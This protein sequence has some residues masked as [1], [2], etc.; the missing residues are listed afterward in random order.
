MVKALYEQ[1]RK[2]AQRLRSLLPDGRTDL[3]DETDAAFG[4]LVKMIHR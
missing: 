4:R 3:S 2:E 1:A